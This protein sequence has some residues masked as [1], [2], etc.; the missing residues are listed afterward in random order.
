MTSGPIC[1]PAVA[2]PRARWS[3]SACHRPPPR[4]SLAPTQRRPG[5]FPHVPGRRAVV[6]AEALDLRPKPRR[7]RWLDLRACQRG[8]DGEEAAI[9]TEVENPSACGK[10]NRCA[11]SSGS[12]S[13][14]PGRVRG[15]KRDHY[16][17]WRAVTR[18]GPRPNTVRGDHDGAPTLRQVGGE[19]QQPARRRSG[20]GAPA[21]RQYVTDGPAE[22]PQFHRTS[23]WARAPP[24][25]TLRTSR[26]RRDR[27]RSGAGRTVK[28]ARLAMYMYRQRS[29]LGPHRGVD[30][31]LEDAAGERPGIVAVPHCGSRCSR[32]SALCS[33]RSSAYRTC[34]CSQAASPLRSSSTMSL[35]SRRTRPSTQARSPTRLP[36]YLVYARR[37]AGRTRNLDTSRN[38]GS[39]CP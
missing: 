34:L 36:S 1:Q 11:G 15:G 29:G 27:R 5:R 26:P 17:A 22:H 33:A 20:T 9:G 19:R 21:H 38:G 2:A 6:R 37:R 25:A 8:P 18:P 32:E 31:L 4:Q 35:S 12:T 14:C 30:Q 13:S 23:P 28:E 16:P 39:R 10:E 3:P 24:G 7:A